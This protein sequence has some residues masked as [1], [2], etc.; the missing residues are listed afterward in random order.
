MAKTPYLASRKNCFGCAVELVIVYLPATMTGAAGLFEKA[1]G[2]ELR[3][4]LV[5][6]SHHD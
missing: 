4:A 6:C 3:K 5:L 1:L 2:P